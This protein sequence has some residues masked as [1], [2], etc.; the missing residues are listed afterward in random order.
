MQALFP[1]GTGEVHQETKSDGPQ[2]RQVV[3]RERRISRMG[4]QRMPQT[5]HERTRMLPDQSDDLVD[6]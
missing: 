6:E 4:N 3:T 1:P 5:D 2:E